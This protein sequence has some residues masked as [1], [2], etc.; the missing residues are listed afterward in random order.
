M[1][2]DKFIKVNNGITFISHQFK[3]EQDCL[4]TNKRLKADF[5]DGSRLFEIE[6]NRRFRPV[7][8]GIVSDIIE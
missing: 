4:R 5:A 3:M 7:G 1:K 6:Q 2:K 8:S